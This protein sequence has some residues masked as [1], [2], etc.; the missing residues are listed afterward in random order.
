[1]SKPRQKDDFGS[2][3]KVSDIAA[4][5]LRQILA[6]TDLPSAWLRIRGEQDECGC[7]NYQ[8][9]LEKDL[10][11]RADVIE[12]PDLRIFI[13]K[14]SIELL[15]GAEMSFAETP[16]GEGFTFNN[17]NSKHAD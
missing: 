2:V 6:K 8:I 4:E 12:N 17:P 16:E 7:I 1:M 10:K 3:L 11:D 14:D 15:R 13:D 5:R 9:T